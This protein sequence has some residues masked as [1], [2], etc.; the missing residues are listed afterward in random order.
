[1][2]ASALQAP[3]GLRA[4]ISLAAPLLRLRSDE[5]LVALFRA[6]NEEA[7][8]VIHD[9]YRQRLFAY[10]RQMLAGSRQDA[11]DALQDVFVRAYGALRADDRAG[12]P[13][14]VA[15]PGGAQPLHRPAAPAGATAGRRLRRLARTPL[16][17]PARR[18][19]APRGP[20][21]GSCRTCAGCPSSSARCCS[22]ARLEG[23]PY[24]E[25]ADALGRQRPGRQVAARARPHGPR[26]RRPRRATP[27][28]PRSATT[29]PLAH[30]RGVR[31][32]GRARRHLRDCAGCRAVPQR[33]APRARGA[34]PRSRRRPRARSGCSPSSA[35]AAAAVAARGRRRR[36]RAAAAP[37]RRRSPAPPAPH[38]P[39]RRSPRSLLG[40]RRGRGRRRQGGAADRR[41]RAASGRAHRSSPPLPLRATEPLSERAAKAVEAPVKATTAAHH[42]ARRGAARRRRPGR[43][44]AGRRHGGRR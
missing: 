9:R 10:A 42:R 2:E 11:E 41:A 4:A 30:G 44:G 35:S 20:A 36:G 38:S 14:R 3:V 8:R 34:S 17:R 22:C 39:R 28:A 25:L 5:Q 37:R 31:A 40:R 33:A 18:D 16:R 12:R 43:G 13:A 27:P 23:L 26:R 15:V 1:M 21:R 24:A 29:S 7:F 6:G 19:R 32:N